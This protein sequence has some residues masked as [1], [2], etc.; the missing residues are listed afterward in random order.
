MIKGENEWQVFGIPGGGKTT[1]LSEK[2]RKAAEKKGG[3]RILVS[4]FTRAAA[5]ELTGRDLPIPKE[6]VGTLHSICYRLLGHPKIAN[7]K[8]KDFNKEYPNSRL[9]EGHQDI[10]ES[11]VDMHLQTRGDEAFAHVQINRARMI[12]KEKWHNDARS[13]D[14]VWEEWKWKNDYVDFTDMIEMVRRQKL[15]PPGIDIGIFDEA[16]D[17]TPQQL[18]LIRFWATE[19]LSYIMIAGDDDQCLYDF[20]GADPEV[21]LNPD[22]PLERKHILN[23][24]YRC[25]RSIQDRARSWIERIQKREPKEQL[26]RTNGIDVAEGEVSKIPLSINT[27]DQ[28]A[29]RLKL[30]LDH[31]PDQTIMVLASCS[32]MLVP[33]IKSLKDRGVPFANRYRRRQ[34]SWN[35]LKASRGM[36]PTQRFLAYLKPAGP[37]FE[38]VR[39]WEH[40]QLSAWVDMCKADG[41]LQ[42][43]GKQKIKDL[44]KLSECQPEYLV[45]TMIDCF[46]GDK[47]D[48]ALKRAPD[49]LSE[50]VL[51]DF[52]NRLEYPL[53]VMENYGQDSLEDEP[54]LLIGTIHS[55]KGGEADNVLLFPDISMKAYRIASQSPSTREAII[56]QFYVGMTR[57]K[58]RLFICEPGTQFKVGI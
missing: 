32:Y 51:T 35:P 26:P 42:K 8:I 34:G 10:N 31:Y 25:P 27:P 13:M 29:Y 23:K 2:I 54:R 43:G 17:F 57:A 46:E 7:A 49:W 28:T 36:S 12:P 14:K 6:N 37:D 3:E 53:K 39:L 30:M 18:D 44:G 40:R 58:E 50:H 55:V 24:S 19:N 22:V 56:R 52:K 38:G 48:E 20:S 1:Y 15:C 33:L 21:F 4:S 41:L 16:Q 5:K 47:L 11:A 9:S 45:A